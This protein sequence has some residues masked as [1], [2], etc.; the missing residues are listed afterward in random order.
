[1]IRAGVCVNVLPIV[2]C[3]LW[4]ASNPDAIEGYAIK[5][6]RGTTDDIKSVWHVRYDGLN[7]DVATC[8]VH[9]VVISGVAPTIP[10]ARIGID[11]R[12]PLVCEAYA[13]TI[14]AQAYAYYKEKVLG[15]RPARSSVFASR[16]SSIRSS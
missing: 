1:M 5:K 10:L 2:F 15:E 3:A 4:A 16:A 8:E 7:Y 12:P 6:G 11:V 9:G 13:R 14:T